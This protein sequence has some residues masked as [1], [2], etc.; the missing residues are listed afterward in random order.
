M[1]GDILSVEILVNGRE[2]DI[3]IEGL[4]TGGTYDFGL[5][6]LN[7]PSTGTPKITFAVVSMGY[8]TTGTATTRARS[9]YG[10]KA[11][12]KVYPNQASAEETVSGSD[13]IVRVVLSDWIYAADDS[14]GGTNGNSGTAPTGIILTGFYTETGTPNNASSS[15]TFAVTN[16]STLEYPKVVANWSWPEHLER[17]TG[18]FALHVVGFHQS[19]RNGRPL[20]CVKFTATDTHANTVTSV[21]TDMTIDRAAGDVIPVPEYIGNFPVASLTNGDLVT[22]NFIAYPW[23]GDSGS[24]MNSDLVANGGSGTAQPTPLVGPVVKLN[25]KSAT[26]QRTFAFVATAADGGND[27]TGAVVARAAYASDALAEAGSKATPF[28]TVGKAVTAI[29]AY[30]NAQYGRNDTGGGE[31]IVGAG[32]FTLAGSAVTPGNDPSAWLIVRGETGAASSAA[33]FNAGSA[34]AKV[35]NWTKF[36][37][38]TLGTA[39]LEFSAIKGMWFDACGTISGTNAGYAFFYQTINVFYITRSTIG[40]IATGV[41]P[42]STGGVAC[43]GI[44]RGN[45]L[46]GLVKSILAYTVLGNKRIAPF[47]AVTTAY[48]TN[49]LSGSQTIPTSDNCIIAY[50]YIGSYFNSNVQA[51]VVNTSFAYTGIAVV[52]NL[53]EQSTTYA[54]ANN[55]FNGGLDGVATPC[56]NYIVWHNTFLGQGSTFAYNGVGSTNLVRSR[57]SLKNNIF[58]SFGVEEDTSGTPNASRAPGNWGVVNMVGCSGNG[59]TYL[60]TMANKFPEFSGIKS[61]LSGSANPADYWKFTDDKAC[62]GGAATAGGGTYTVQGNSPAIGLPRD[63]VLPFDLA[64]SRR[65]SVGTAG[66]YGF[67]NYLPSSGWWAGQ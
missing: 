6:A 34:S 42:Y 40:N 4:G 22:C 44:I 2:A 45:N 21:V 55:I 38:L 53:I 5:G 57:W 39:G 51:I 13:V 31:V 1:T 61:D 12:R 8:D 64:G 66:A 18:D 16:S 35:T 27:T 46:S 19:A 33:V 43:P 60:A 26:Y 17:I 10:V 65:A 15:S 37:N 62:K 49:Y 36:S 67:G 48:I 58:D 54:S 59:F 14:S 56:D 20:A 63:W 28:L 30:N 41:R 52:Q 11:V 7:D 24:L 47:D 50:N 29:A 3:K 9:V 32:N 25:D 23:V